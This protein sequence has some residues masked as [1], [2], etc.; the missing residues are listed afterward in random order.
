MICIKCKKEFELVERN[1]CL[2][3]KQNKA[4]YDKERRGKM[5]NNSWIG[6]KNPPDT[7]SSIQEEVLIGSL[8]GDGSLYKYKHHI[9]AGFTIARKFEDKEYLQYQFDLFKDF[10]Y[11]D[12]LSERNYLDKR[13]NKIYCTYSFRTQCAKVFTALHDKW[14]IDGIKIVP[15]DLKLTQ[16]I[17]AIWFCDDGSIVDTGKT[18][19]RISIYTDGFTEIEVRFLKNLLDQTIGTEFKLTHKNSTKDPIKGFYLYI[20]KREDVVKFINYIKDVFPPMNRK[21]S[22]WEDYI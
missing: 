19:K 8:L 3:C 20:N 17:C 22:R 6:N 9:N 2:N 10:C 13:T 11:K 21:S 18:G 7:L 5:A 12:S 14:Y 16:L 1:T 15:N 4:I